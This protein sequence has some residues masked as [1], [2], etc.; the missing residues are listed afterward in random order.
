VPGLNFSPLNSRTVQLGHDSDS[1]ACPACPVESG[2][3]LV[4]NWGET[5]LCPLFNLGRISLGLNPEL[6]NDHFKQ[7][8]FSYARRHVLKEA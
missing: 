8:L 3:R 6:R 1:E 5:Y 4:F 2:Y 7:S